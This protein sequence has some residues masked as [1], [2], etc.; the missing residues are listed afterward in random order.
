MASMKAYS[1]GLIPLLNHSALASALASV[2]P[3]VQPWG[4]GI[5]PPTTPQLLPMLVI[6]CQ[7]GNIILLY[8]KSMGK[9]SV[10]MVPKNCYLP[11]RGD[12]GCTLYSVQCAT[13]VSPLWPNFWHNQLPNTRCSLAKYTTDR[14]QQFLLSTE[15]PARD[16]GTSHPFTWPLT[17]II[18][19][20][21]AVWLTG[22]DLKKD[23]VSAPKLRYSRVEQSN[24]L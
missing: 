4:F 5:F 21:V 23:G 15:P 7:A 2:A 14:K 22:V 24:V 6:S 1:F 3:V 9:K 11:Q 8:F 12:C 17:S 16:Y 18:A 20:I 10:K 19:S 13:T